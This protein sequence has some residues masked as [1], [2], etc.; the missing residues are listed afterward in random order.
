MET[1][2]FLQKTTEIPYAKMMKYMK[3][4]GLKVTKTSRGWGEDAISHKM[5][6][7]TTT[8]EIFFKK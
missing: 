4:V 7:P 1:V 3:N 2:G 6:K 8:D 5:S